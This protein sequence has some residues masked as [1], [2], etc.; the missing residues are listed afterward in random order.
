MW[1]NP[2]KRQDPYPDW[3][4]DCQEALTPGFEILFDELTAVGWTREEIRA[5]FVALLSANDLTN[6]ANAELETELAIMRA[7]MRLPRT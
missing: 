5:S 3:Q 6:E 2:P 4:L 7:R 1:F